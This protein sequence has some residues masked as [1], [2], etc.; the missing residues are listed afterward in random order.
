[1]SLSS[2]NFHN[3][4]F[5]EEKNIREISCKFTKGIHVH[6]AFLIQINCQSF[7]FLINGYINYFK[8]KLKDYFNK[9]IKIYKDKD[10]IKIF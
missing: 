9:I 8:I 4:V 7:N 3:F 5:F 10:I 2:I 1:M 6:F